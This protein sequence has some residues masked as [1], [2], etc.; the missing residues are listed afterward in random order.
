MSSPHYVPARLRTTSGT[1]LSLEMLQGASLSHHTSEEDIPTQVRQP[2]FTHPIFDEIA[3]RMN[4]ARLTSYTGPA[5][6]LFLTLL[7]PAKHIIESSTIADYDTETVEA[8]SYPTP[9]MPSMRGLKITKR[10]TYSISQE[11]FAIAASYRIW[12]SPNFGARTSRHRAASF[13]KP[14]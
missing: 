9:K 3:C 13:V 7:H 8:L 14:K 5:D 10:A 12:T 11:E 2:E 4:T 6:A 1:P